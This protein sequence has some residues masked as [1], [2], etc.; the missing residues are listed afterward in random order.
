[1]GSTLAPRRGGI[2]DIGSNSVRLVIF[3]VQGAAILPTFNE[4]VMAG[5]G[6]DLM[7]TGK[8]SV[9]GRVSAMSA[10][11]R[12]RAILDAL[13]IP[14]VAPVATAAVRVAEDGPSFVKEAGKVLR[15]PVRVLSGQD[16]AN[17]AA[18][19]VE[20]GFF[21]GQ[22]LVGDL[23]GSS[24]EFKLIGKNKRAGESLMLGPLSIAQETFVEAKV[25]KIVRAQL[26]K[27]DNLYA[28]KGSFYAVGGAW[29]SIA[30]FLMELKGYP[31]QVLHGYHISKGDLSLVARACIQSLTDSHLGAQLALIDKRRTSILPYAAVIVDEVLQRKALGGV[32][33]SSSGLREGV[34]RD[35]MGAA[36]GDSLLDGIRAFA[37]LNE[38]QVNFGEGLFRF[39]KPII[40]PSD[41]LFGTK[42]AKTRIYKAACMLADSAGHYHPDHRAEMAYEQALRGPFS[43]LNHSQRGFLA[44]ALG[45][46]YSRKYRRP[47]AYVGLNS[48][49]EALHARQL[50]AAMR[51]GAIF[52]GRS[53]P[54][55]ER[56]T[57]LR[58]GGTLVL[59]IK[60]ADAGLMSD[61]IERRLTQLA[62]LMQLDD[63]V[64][65]GR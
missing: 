47:D 34:I 14:I 48:P 62:G 44:H 4:K 27:S 2:I 26:S 45:R 25:R 40:P 56:A 15:V 39:I 9:E 60:K 65:I 19:G 13:E 1:M 42:K 46:R 6:R 10:L 29:R 23:G 24:L 50:G 53:E 37:R 8:L 38:T 43:G 59:Q 17:Y 35:V 30:K 7:E 20:M 21:E 33:I 58:E 63:R 11:V 3:D 49:E 55:L 16:E 61:T 36:D 54:I 12:Y 18:A 32:Y 57:L 51:L 31:L 28:S 64:Q 5:L 22:G 41:D 52:S